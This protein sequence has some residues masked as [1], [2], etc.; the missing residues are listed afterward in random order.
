M[1]YDSPEDTTVPYLEKYAERRAAARCRRSTPT[2]PG[3]RGPPL[4]HRPRH[5]RGRRRDHGRRQRRP[6]ADRRARPPRRAGRRRG[7]RVRATCRAASRSAARSEVAACRGWPGCRSTGSPGSAPTTPPTRSRPTTGRSCEQVGIESDAGFEIGI[8]LVA[9]ARRRRL[10][11]AEIPTIWLDR[12]WRVE[13]QG[14]GPGCPATCAG[15]ATPSARGCRE[16]ERPRH[17]IVRLHRRLRRA[18]AA[19]RGPRGRRHRQPLEVRPG[20]HVLRRRTPA[21]GSSRA[22]AATST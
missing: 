9:K 19:R 6:P 10:P 20:R 14:A 22:T 15:T 5:G 21:T 1:V 17:R 3:R 11:V 18:G 4:R 13:L 8:E 12:G 7:R 16:H 2:G